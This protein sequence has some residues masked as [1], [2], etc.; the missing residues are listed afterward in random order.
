MAYMSQ[1][2]KQKIAARVKPILK[3]YNVKGSLRVRNH[4]TIVLTVRSGTL[5]FIHDLVNNRMSLLGEVQLDKDKLREKYTLDVNPY[6]FQEH[7]TGRSLAFLSEVFEAMKS[8]DWYDR[9]DAQVDYFD[10][11]YYV[12]VNIGDWNKPYALT[13]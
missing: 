13:A 3:A 4:S 9:S 11:A 12:D 10:T 8:A 6:W 1:E 2:K 5:D 7:Y